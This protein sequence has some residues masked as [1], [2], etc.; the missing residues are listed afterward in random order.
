MEPNPV[1]P[2]IST[3]RGDSA[4]AQ[5]YSRLRAFAQPGATSPSFF[6]STTYVQVYSPLQARFTASVALPWR[7]PQFFPYVA[8]VTVIPEAS[9]DASVLADSMRSL[10]S[11]VAIASTIGVR[12]IP[13][14]TFLRLVGCS[15]SNAR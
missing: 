2:G 11:T 13:I 1:S 5:E 6:T 14:A 7:A 10:A 8:E 15:R 12:N 3:C 9:P 4:G